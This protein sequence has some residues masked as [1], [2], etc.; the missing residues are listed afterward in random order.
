MNWYIGQEIVCVKSHS[1]KSVVKGKVYTIKSLEKRCCFMG[2]DVGIIDQTNYINDTANCR[3]CGANMKVFKTGNKWW[4]SEL[5]FA[6]L[7]YNQDALN[8]LLEEVK[9]EKIND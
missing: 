5:L 4:F 8:E 7:E 6:P 9:V 3:S 2:I 1:L